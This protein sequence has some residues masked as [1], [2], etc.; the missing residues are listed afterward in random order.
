MAGIPAQVARV[1]RG[2]VRAGRALRIAEDVLENPGS[3]TSRN[4][5]S[6]ISGLNR[7]REMMSGEQL[8]VAVQVDGALR[9]LKG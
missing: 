8:G 6:A 5:D 3:W 9:S 4:I 1:M 7:N 2:M